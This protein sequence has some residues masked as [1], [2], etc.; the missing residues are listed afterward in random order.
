VELNPAAREFYV[1]Q[2]TT[3]PVTTGWAASFDAGATWVEGDAVENTT[4][5]WRWL[6]AGPTF[7]PTGAPTAEYTDLAPVGDS[8]VIYPLLRCT[9]NPEV[10]VI[11]GTAIN[12]S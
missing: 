4:D 8:Q 9:D 10:I 6:I 2:V 1:Q 11:L 12:I 5:T 3:N 7:N